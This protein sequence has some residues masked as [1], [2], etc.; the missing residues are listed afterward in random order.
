[1]KAYAQVLPDE[2]RAKQ[3]GTRIDITNPDAFWTWLDRPEADQR[4]RGPIARLRDAVTK[5]QQQ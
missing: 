1:M 4:R 3:H 5:R 2:V